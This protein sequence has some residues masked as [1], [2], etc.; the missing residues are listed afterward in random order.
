MVLGRSEEALVEA[1]L[2]ADLDPVSAP[3]WHALGAMLAANGQHAAAVEQLR[4]TMELSPG[5]Y[6][7]YES[8]VESYLALDRSA[9][10]LA[11][12]QRSPGSDTRELLTALVYAATDRTDEARELIAPIETRA[13]EGEPLLATLAALHYEMGDT[14]QALVWLQRAVEVREPG[15]VEFNGLGRFNDLRG[16]LRFGAIIAP[17]GLP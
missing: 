5:L 7:G 4:T 14:D 9:E 11:T 13:L 6:K 10:A 8:L 15:V 16:D 17:L 12:A 1:R 2:A 3:I